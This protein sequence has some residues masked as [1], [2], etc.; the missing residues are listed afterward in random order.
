VGYRSST[1]NS[2]ALQERFKPGDKVT[3]S[4]WVSFVR[5][6]KEV[7]FVGLRD[8][9]GTIQVVV[10][11]TQSFQGRLEDVVTVEGVLAERAGG[12]S[13]EF[14]LRAEM[15]K[16]ENHAKHPLPLGAGPA[17]AAANAAYADQQTPQQRDASL[18]YRYL[19][20][21]VRPYLQRNLRIRGAAALAMRNF[22]TNEA[23]FL[24]VETPTLFKS[25]PEGAREFLVPVS[26]TEKDAKPKFYALVQSPQQYKQM[27]M[28]AGI[29]RYFQF[30]RCYRDEGGR[31][32]RQPEFTQLDLEMSFVRESREVERVI[33]GVVKAGWKAAFQLFPSE[34]PTPPDELKEFP[35]MRLED[36]MRDYGSDKPNL[37]YGMKIHYEDSVATVTAPGLWAAM[38]RKEKDDLK[39][40]LF[41]EKLVDDAR[42]SG[43]DYVVTAKD[44][45]HK[46]LGRARLILAQWMKK[47][48]VPLPP[49][50]MKEHEPIWIT[51]FGMF[52]PNEEV[53]KSVSCVHHPFTAPHPDDLPK[54]AKTLQAI[55][56]APNPEEKW[57]QQQNLFTGLRAQHYDLVCDGMELGGGS[58]RI[59][60][61][62]LQQRVFQDALGISEED[63]QAKFGHLLEAL[64]LGAPPHGGFA[65]GFDRF[66]TLMCGS[67]SISD[68]LAF[69]K[70]S[71]GTDPM[72]GAPCPLTDAEVG[73]VLG[74]FALKPSN[75]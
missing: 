21:R 24:E 9:F 17:T 67:Q 32:D 73:A 34:V 11:H 25:T 26:S 35:R 62:E 54:L 43:E 19:D 14:E 23:G 52:E 60:S 1:L 47:K 6:Q 22:M 48:G 13:G 36:A 39:K 68:T 70:S 53:E 37:S 16:V 44:A 59:H 27:L 3:L 29:D 74:R 31:A 41:Q 72:T 55:R 30:A 71:M 75:A 12:K 10:P 69:P 33:E 61:A 4:G 63:C 56:D 18:K 28:V 42:G 40:F 45:S 58:I 5:K 51:D 46:R 66:M 64:S 65:L 2:N 20:L 50:I 7:S 49:G 38:S 8:A 57:R 15:V